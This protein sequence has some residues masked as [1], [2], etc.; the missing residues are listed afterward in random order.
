MSYGGAPPPGQPD[1]LWLSPTAD[2]IPHSLI[3]LCRYVKLAV[4]F[5]PSG[6]SHLSLPPVFRHFWEVQPGLNTGLCKSTA[7]SCGFPPHVFPLTIS[8]PVL[9]LPASSNI[10]HWGIWIM[11]HRWGEHPT[12]VFNL[13][14][15]LKGRRRKTSMQLPPHCSCIYNMST[16]TTSWKILFQLV[17]L[18]AHFCASVTLYGKH[19]SYSLSFWRM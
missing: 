16:C 10:Q 13:C 9:P 3:S 18:K 8:K 19:F 11:L 14:Q 15:C 7:P 4:M 5:G 2:E 1:S 6:S 12:L 17:S